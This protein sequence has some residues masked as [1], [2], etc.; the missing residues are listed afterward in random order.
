MV[1]NRERQFGV[2]TLKPIKPQKLIF[3]G[4]TNKSEQNQC[5]NC[6]QKHASGRCPTKGKHCFRCTQLNHFSTKCKAKNV[7]KVEI[8]DGFRMD[9]LYSLTVLSQG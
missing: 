3:N 7:N 4:N 1:P 5:G 2:Q 9:D 6:A 8:T